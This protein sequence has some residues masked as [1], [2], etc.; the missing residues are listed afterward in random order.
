VISLWGLDFAA[1]IGGGAI[2]TEFVFNLGGIGQ[3]LADSI[4]SLDVPPVLT[5]TMFIAFFVVLFNTIVDIVY[6]WLDPR[7]R[8]A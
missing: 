4:G 2:V 8:L 7:I 5:L 1:L 6:A 3:Y